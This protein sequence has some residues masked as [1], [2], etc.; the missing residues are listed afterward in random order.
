M[1]LQ[2][3]PPRR[4]AQRVTSESADG[5]RY[6]VSP[7]PAP[8]PVDR[9]KAPPAPGPFWRARVDFSATFAPLTS[10]LAASTMPA[11][12]ITPSSDAPLRT[13]SRSSDIPS[14]LLTRAFNGLPLAAIAN[15]GVIAVPLQVS[16]RA[17]VFQAVAAY[18]DRGIVAAV[19]ALHANPLVHPP[20][21]GVIEQHRFREYLEQVH[22]VI[23]PL[24]VRQFMRDDR[25]DLRI[26]KPC[27]RRDRQ[28][29][30]WA[31]ARRSPPEPAATAER[32]N[33]TARS[34]PISLLHRH[35]RAATVAR[36]RYVRNLAQPLHQHETARAA[37]AEQHNPGHPQ[38][39]QPQ[40]RFRL[41]C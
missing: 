34:I 21:R 6:R 7:T 33:R 1:R 23:Q 28:Q 22:E 4:R 27:Q 2:E 37:Q 41:R 35:H 29:H 3:R 8:R 12:P 19:L 17:Y 38:P 14:N 39:H 31:D 15:C 36:Y 25:L 30:D 32:Q 18:R 10:E 13:P 11:I 9:S 16:Q 40:H 24:D 26:R 5:R 20:D